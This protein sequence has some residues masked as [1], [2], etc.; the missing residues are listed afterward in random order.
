MST[1]EMEVFSNGQLLV[2]TVLMLVGGEVFLSLVSL[3]SK[4]SKLR[5]Q[6]AHKSRRV[7]IHHVAELEM[8]PAAAADIDNPT[9]STADDVTSKSLEHAPD[10]RLRRD[11]VRSLFFVVLAIFLVVHVLGAG[12]I[13]AYILHAS[14]AARRTLRDKAL[15]VWTF[16]VFT[17]VSTFSNCGFMPTNENMAVFQRDTGLQLLL[18]SQVLVGNTLFAPPPRRPGAWSSRRL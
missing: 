17:T 6:A 15:N 4:W 2:L 8:P 11:A 10:T 5:K 13:A 16:A 7:E 14:P 12:A 3:A 1:V 18:V 9:S